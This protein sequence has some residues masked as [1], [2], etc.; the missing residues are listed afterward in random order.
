MDK[1]LVKL[2]DGSQREYEKGTTPY[3]VAESISPR[4][5]SDAL[6]A[7]VDGVIKDLNTPL[8]SD[9]ELSILTFKDDEGKQTYWHSSSHLM[10]HAIQELYPE[11][12]FGVGPS[13]D[14]GFYYDIDINTHLTEEDLPKIEEKM[15]EIAKNGNPFQ[16]QEL[17]REEA[18][19]YFK[20][21]GDRLTL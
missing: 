1:I 21:K 5:A 17:S 20:K 3:Q 8:F 16:R 6:V 13:I 10:A 11:A 9:V 14:N 18:V 7:K 2:P 15:S 19:N 4:L 12:K